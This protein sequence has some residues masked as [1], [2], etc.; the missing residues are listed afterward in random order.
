M[1]DIFLLK[2]LLTSNQQKAAMH[3]VRPVS[4]RYGL[5]KMFSLLTD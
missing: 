5:T 3:T 4:C 1:C 2:A